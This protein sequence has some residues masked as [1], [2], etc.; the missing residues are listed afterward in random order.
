[1]IE[2]IS[3]GSGAGGGSRPAAERGSSR[4]VSPALVH[5]AVLRVPAQAGAGSKALSL[6]RLRPELGLLPN[7]TDDKRHQLKM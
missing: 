6:T 4:G 7:S 5:S 2:Q 1:M 3:G